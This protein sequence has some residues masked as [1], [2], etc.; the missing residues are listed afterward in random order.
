MSGTGME[1]EL[2]EQL[3]GSAAEAQKIIGCMAEPVREKLDE[4][5]TVSGVGRLMGEYL[6]LGDDKNVDAYYQLLALQLELKKQ[7]KLR[8]QIGAC[9]RASAG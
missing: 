6:D 7:W 3:K 2:E 9:R 1:R 4:K 5:L 8:R